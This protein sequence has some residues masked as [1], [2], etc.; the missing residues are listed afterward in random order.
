MDLIEW[1]LPLRI[2][3]DFHIHSRFSR[4]TSPALNL[5]SL[6]ENAR[7]KGLDLLGTGDITHRKWLAE[8]SEQLEDNDGIFHLKGNKEK[9][10]KFVI[11][12][13]VAT[14]FPHDSKSRKIHHCL[15]LPDLESAKQ[16]SGKLQQKGNLEEDGRPILNMTAAELVEILKGIASEAEIYPAH[17]WTPWW[18]LFGANFGFDS[19]KECYQEYHSEIHALETG[20]S[21]DP[22]MNWRVSELDKLTLLSN[23]DC[24]S[25]YPFRLGREANIFELENLTYSS[26]IDAIR[27]KGRGRVVSTIETKPEYGKYHW[28]GH[29]N[30]GVSF[31][32]DESKKIGAKCPKCGKK[33]TRGVEERVSELADRPVGFEA[34]GAAGCSY[35]YPLQ[36]LIAETMGESS[37]LSKNVQQLYDKAIAALK[38]EFNIT[39]FAPIASITEVLGREIAQLIASVRNDTAEIIPGYDGVYGKLKLMAKEERPSSKKGLD[40]W[41]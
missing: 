23:S 25:A 9:T 41:I 7:I 3:G 14:V 37:P 40:V 8:V 1:C 31:S 20:L 13:E 32:S 39:L 11:T 28:T 19:L 38:N 27:R 22:P 4:A 15:L 17:A 16:L 35:A 2:I 12:S 5:H 36:E 21:S 34:N 29:R 10:P 33:L 24:H 30:C 26:L 6:A 18:S